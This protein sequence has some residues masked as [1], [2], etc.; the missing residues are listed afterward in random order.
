LKIFIFL[1]LLKSGANMFS[2]IALFELRYQLK[3]PLFYVAALIFFL[4]AFASVTIDNIKIGGGANVNLN[5]PYALVLTSA[6]MAL[7][8]IFAATA[9]VSNTVLRD[10]ETGFAGIVQA[11]RMSKF[12][13]LMGRFSG[14]FTVSVL[15][16]CAAP[17]GM[18]L[19]VQ[20]PWVDSEKIGPFVLTHYLYAIF[21]FIVP[22][23]WVM[24]AL[25]FAVAIFTRSM[26]WTYMAVIAFLVLYTV[27]SVL[28][29]DPANDV[30][31]AWSD[32]TGLAAWSQDTRYWTA[33]DRNSQLPP[34]ASLLGRNRLLWSFIGLVL[35]IVGYNAFRFGKKADLAVKKKEG[36]SQTPPV[37]IGS[38]LS[39]ANSPTENQK[40]SSLSALAALTRFEFSA[41]FKSPA[42]LVLLAL[43]LFNAWG[44]LTGTSER[45]GI[46]SFPLTSVV[47]DALV[48]S[49]SIIAL[50]VAVFYAGEVIWRNRDRKIHE[51][52]DATSTPN[53]VFLAPKVLAVTLV[54]L[55]CYFVS[56]VQGICYQL[57]H[58]FRPT[59]IASYLGDF[60]LWYIAPMMYVAFVTAVLAIFIQV[61]V[62][63]KAAGWAV[64][65][66]FVVAS[67][68][69]GTA[70]FEN[71]LYRYGSIPQ[72]P[73][74]DMNGAG[75]FWQAA[76]WFQAYWLVFA[77]LLLLLSHWL[78]RRGNN[79]SLKVRLAKLNH[80]VRGRTGLPFVFLLVTWVGLGSW[81]F[82]NTH[83]LNQ[84]E[85]KDARE[86]ML[87]NTE[88]ALTQYADQ[89]RPKVIHVD[90]A[91]DM[92]PKQGKAVTKGGYLIE[93][94]DSVPITQMLVGWDPNTEIKSLK[95][96]GAT[97][98]QDF[99]DF[100]YRLY[101]FSPAL[102]P[103]EQRQITFETLIQRRGFKNNSG[104]SR[105]VDNGSFLNNFEI[106]P[107]LTFKP[108]QLQ[109]RS[110]RRKLGL[111]AEVRMAK[112]EDKAA[113]QYNYLGGFS[114]WVTANLTLTTDAD[115][116]PI[117]PGV[118]VSDQTSQGRRT[119]K[120]KTDKPIL[121]FFSMQS[122]FYKQQQTSW[123][124]A[125]GRLV[126]LAVFYH[127]AHE[128]NVERMLNA[129][130]VS[131]DVF[132]QRF[133]PYQ[134]HQARIIEFPRYAAF[135]QAFAGTV[136]YSEEIGFAQNFDD[137]QADEKIDLVTYVTAHEIAHQW[138]A[139]QVIGADKQGSTMLSET[140]AQY[141]ALL[142]MEKLYGR[143]QLRKF[144]K[145]E[146]DGYLRARG[147]EAIEELP[148][149]KVENQGYIH[150]QKGALA[151]F[152]LKEAVGE[153]NVN[154]ALRQL[155]EQFAFKAAPYPDTMD[156][157]QLLRKQVGP[158][159]QELITDLFERITLYDMKATKATATP[160][161]GGQF[162]VSFT[163]SARKMFADGKGKETDAPLNELFDLGVFS[164]E[165]GKKGYTKQSVLALERRPLAS[166]EQ[167]VTLRVAQEPKFVGVDPFNFRIDRNSDDNFTAVTF[168]K[169]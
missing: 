88:K 133:S 11:T 101:E 24:G 71:K 153:D 19:G 72:V 140:F 92:Y 100:A 83:L 150:Y 1:P 132:S 103:K 114:D 14:A 112:L 33:S 157:L 35:L 147:T 55:A 20:M 165:P 8:G 52:V 39:Q 143:E 107:V 156:F 4:L 37:A 162:E 152:W 131:L 41:V 110:K 81:I 23:M 36:H 127:P 94:R 151:M 124:P 21:I 166:G 135:A 69:L 50:I 31:S 126:D 7:F 57:V 111:P 158:Q 115:Q 113:N 17:L 82:Y 120:T 27:S 42:F 68:A 105:V 65:L 84:Y 106:A 149:A 45:N 99:Q 46:P 47:V 93:N 95:I 62:P 32:P 48:A 85:T 139:H 159:H 66:L 16:V 129:M 128:H 167:Q 80:Y 70:G 59:S 146:L 3:S 102:Q 136:P 91:V 54:L 40:I 56:A 26:M 58:D 168:V 34:L 137:K 51:V 43:G 61:V 75:H 154:Q 160:L 73:L 53:W 15:V 2:K 63:N 96:D 142:V 67:I 138:W 79:T 130:K 9:F 29:A 144:M 163:V 30:V 13:Y 5:S 98:K 87:A 28:L 12:D 89:P 64:M 104:L 117:V 10:D 123:Q 121:N 109:E 119:L 145:N 97:V 161:P 76:A 74:S 38:L 44:S 6:I 122:G 18:L 141:S 90:L 108:G 78:W 134:F 49:F 164:V 116:V 155:I 148:L 77:L 169:K 22:S 60:G 86:K 125:Q 118:M 25:F